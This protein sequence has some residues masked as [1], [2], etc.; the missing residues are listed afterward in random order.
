[1]HC[2]NIRWEQKKIYCRCQ[3][4]EGMKESKI[5]YFSWWK[6]GKKS[7]SLLT[8][9]KKWDVQF[10]HF[11]WSYT[12]F[13]IWLGEIKSIN[14]EQ[15]KGNPVPVKKF[16]WWLKLEKQMLVECWWGGAD[17]GLLWE[18]PISFTHCL[19]IKQ[20]MPWNCNK[21]SSKLY[22]IVEV[23]NSSYYFKYF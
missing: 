13:N 7:F 4:D 10:V 21:K 2:N 18:L 6:T 8:A 1:M 5:G 19:E 9:T 16:K 23:C 14:F 22:Q 15:F 3:A 11:Y 17:A 20:K 12:S